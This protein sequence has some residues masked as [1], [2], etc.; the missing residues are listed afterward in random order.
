VLTEGRQ[1]LWTSHCTA[2]VGRRPIRGAGNRVDAVAVVEVMVAPAPHLVGPEECVLGEFV[3][4]SGRKRPG[5]SEVDCATADSHRDKTAA[6]VVG[7]V[8]VEGLKV[9]SQTGEGE[10]NTRQRT[11]LAVGRGRGWQQ[12]M[13]RGQGTV[14]AG[15]RGRAEWG[16]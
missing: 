14:C 10:Q 16:L 7:V 5:I 3:Q 1:R 12:Q 9:E 13:G 4:A 2:F 11:L 15:A 8:A 6:A